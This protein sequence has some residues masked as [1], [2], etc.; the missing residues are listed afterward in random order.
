M[1][2]EDFL[3]RGVVGESQKPRAAILGI[4]DRLRSAAPL[5]T[6]FNAHV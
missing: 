2:V 5:Q 4:P 3:G 1:D 6:N